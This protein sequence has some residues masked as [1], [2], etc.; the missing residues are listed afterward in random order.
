MSAPRIASLID[1]GWRAS[2]GRFEE[3]LA[4]HSGIAD[5]PEAGARDRRVWRAPL[6]SGL[7]RM[8]AR[9]RARC[10]TGRFGSI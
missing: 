6:G 5:R 8:A 9:M 1:A 10:Q 4:R 7:E 2:N 3:R